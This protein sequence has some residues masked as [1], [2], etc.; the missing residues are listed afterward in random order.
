MCT[1]SNLERVSPV[2]EYIDPVAVFTDSAIRGISD[3]RFVAKSEVIA[4]LT[5]L[6]THV[7]RIVPQNIDTDVH[8]RRD[9]VPQIPLS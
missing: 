6:I 5:D 9:D 4:G 8:A 2:E 3:V 1:G 7:S